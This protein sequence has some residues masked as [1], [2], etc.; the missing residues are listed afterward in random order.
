MELPWSSQGYNPSAMTA[1]EKPR[2]PR[3][4]WTLGCL[5]FLTD[6]GGESVFPLLPVYLAGLGAGPRFLGLVEGVA[7]GLSSALGV[8]SGRISDRRGR[9]KGLTVFGYSLSGA[10]RPLLAFATSPWQV[11]AV[12]WLDRTGKGIRNAPRDALIAD[13]TPKAI[14]GRAFG[15]QKAM[16]HLGATLGPLIVWFLMRPEGLGVSLATVFLLA[17]VPGILTLLVGIFGV[18]EAPAIMKPKERADWSKAGKFTPAFRGYLLL[19]FCFG[20]G[21]SS[22]AFLLTR[23]REVGVPLAQLPLMWAAFSGL[24]SLCSVPAGYLADRMSR[25]RLLIVGWL[26]Y[27]ATYSAFARVSSPGAMWG[28]FCAYAL[29]SGLTEGTERALVSDLVGQDVRATAFGAFQLMT[30]VST[31]LA[32]LLCGAIWHWQGPGMAFGLAAMLAAA[33]SLGL[34]FLKLPAPANTSGV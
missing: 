10:V 19:V 29:F 22:D 31:L 17:A 1:P 34:A 20:L 26:V 30:G 33:G 25:K 5:S 23:A 3:N 14:W 8:I 21:L 18:K 11:L 2:L 6:L 7:D 13:S 27:A 16:D 9:R 4:V 24:K 28:I 12:R 15:M 32:S